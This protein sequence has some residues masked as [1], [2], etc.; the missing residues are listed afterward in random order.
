MR[1]GGANSRHGESNKSGWLTSDPDP[2][3]GSV[4]FPGT[5]SSSGPAGLY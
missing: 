2:G 5:S 4:V 3:S 1:A